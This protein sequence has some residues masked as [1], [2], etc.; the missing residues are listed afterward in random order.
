MHPQQIPYTIIALGT[1]AT[2]GTWGGAKGIVLPYFLTDLALAPAIGSA[3]FTAT[4]VGSFIGS[5]SFAWLTSRFGLSRVNQA[6]AILLLAITGVILFLNVPLLLYPAFVLF[7]LGSSMVELTSTLPISILYA[8][9]QGGIM[10]LTHGFFGLGT[11]VGS[12]LAGL[13]MARGL[14]WRLPMAVAVVLVGCW[15]YAFHRQPALSLPPR[16]AGEPGSG[17]LLKDPL[18]WAATLALTAGVAAENGAGIW[19]ATYLSEGKGLSPAA[20]TAGATCF[21]LGFTAARLLG[22]VLTRLGSVRAVLLCTS[23]GAAGLTGVVLLPGQW[24]W[25]TSLAGL[26]VGIIFPTCLT[27]VAVRYQSRSNQ[28]FSLMYGMANVAGISTAPAMGLVME[29]GS[30]L[31]AAMWVEIGFYLAVI[32]LIGCYG[33][34]TVRQ[35]ADA[36]SPAA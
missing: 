5:S 1:I 23:I 19:L 16:A 31:T 33:W 6:G 28:V 20:T 21:F 30:G 15:A 24:F 7:G 26:G 25:L 10:S 2:L 11:L 18:V 34:A 22:P 9:R 32:L 12:T 35:K 3:I 8:G 17:G 36:R 13:A 4:S 29:Y 27:L 14:N